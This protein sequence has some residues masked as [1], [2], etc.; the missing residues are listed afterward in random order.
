MR[1]TIV[2]L[3]TMAC[4]FFSWAAVAAAAG[5]AGAAIDGSYIVTVKAGSDPK[6]VA[7]GKQAKTKYVYRSAVNGFAAELSDAQ[8]SKLRQDSRVAAI[9][10]DR[11]VTADATQT[12]AT[13][14]LD[15][16]DQ[17]NLPLSTTYTYNS[18]GAGVYAYVI[19]TGI[20]TAHSNFGGRAAN[21]YDAFGG[22][23]QD[24]NGHGTHVAGTI[25]S[26]T[27]GVAKSVQPARRARAQ[28]LGLRLD[29]G[30]H[31]GDELA[32]QQRAAPGR[33]EHVARRRLLL[34]AQLGGQQPRQLR[35]VPGRRGRQRGPERVQRLAGQR[36]GGV[37]DRGLRPHATCAPRSPTTAPAWTATRR[38]SRSRRPGTTA[39]RTRSAA[40]RWRRRTWPASAR[41]TR[42]A[43]A[44]RR[45]RAC[46]AG[47][48]SSST[49]NVI[50]SQPERHAEPPA[51]HQRALTLRARAAGPGAGRAALG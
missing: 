1:R 18:T 15:R 24:C 30:H 12:N 35:R 40:R 2:A 27:Y 14:G 28:L 32:A 50:R 8:V 7:D 10:Q 20:Y 34:D 49:P 39:A 36:L 17:R 21:V 26:A 48:T 33:G 46:R 44:T 16:I 6:A 29:V 31:R 47:S 11:V 38:V 25:G 9:E 43:T 5:Q 37:H 4:A 19:D 41:S 45:P 13:W 23:G 3:A 51:V 42:A 22:N